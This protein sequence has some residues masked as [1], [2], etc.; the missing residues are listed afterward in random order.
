MLPARPPEPAIH[1]TSP[2]DRPA[3][4]AP[5]IQVSIGR[6]EVRAVPPPPPSAKPRAGPAPMTLE[7][8]LRQRNGG[9]KG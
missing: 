2:A 4:A 6:I 3:E 7:E 1:L 5:T 9:G 8:Y